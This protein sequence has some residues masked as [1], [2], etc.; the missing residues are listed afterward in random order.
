MAIIKQ[1]TESVN[2]LAKLKQQAKETARQAA[3]KTE[4]IRQGKR[5]QSNQRR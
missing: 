2:T 5:E 4:Q 3:L 1:L